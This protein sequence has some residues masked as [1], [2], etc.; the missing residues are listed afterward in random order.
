MIEESRSPT[1]SSALRYMHE[2]VVGTVEPRAEAQA[3]F[4]ADLDRRLS[5]TVWN[6]GGCASWY[7]DKTGRNSTLW[8]DATW[9]FRRRVAS[10]KPSEYVLGRAADRRVVAPRP[11]S[12]A[13]TAPSVPAS[14]PSRPSIE[15]A[16]RPEA[17]P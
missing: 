13:S 1:S 8:P 15:A 5:R 10:F 12:P 14:A 11:A 4:I 17:R 9:R 16:V 3:T 7:M 2:K 6:T